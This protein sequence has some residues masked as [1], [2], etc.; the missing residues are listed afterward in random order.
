MPTTTVLE[1][2]ASQSA[3]PMSIVA[4]ATGKARNFQTQLQYVKVSDDGKALGPSTWGRT[5]Y[6][7]D[8]EQLVPV[9]IHDA[10]GQQ[11]QFS[12]D[13]N[14]FQLIKHKTVMQKDHYTSD[15]NIKNIYY[16]EVEQMVKEVTGASFVKTIHHVLRH[17]SSPDPDC[18]TIT[19]PLYKVHVD[20]TPNRVA[21]T[22][23]L[24]LGDKADELLKKRYAL[25]NIW[26]LLKPVFK[27]PLA[28]CDGSTVPD[29]EFVVR[30]LNIPNG[31]A[32][33]ENSAVRA[34]EGHMWYYL[35]GQDVDEVTFIRCWDSNP[36]VV[37]RC[38]HSAVRDA[39]MEELADRESIEARCLVFWD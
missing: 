6:E 12:L 28:Y 11:E 26:R 37:K 4:V 16:P 20:S 23:K 1:Q 31:Q 9:T 19:R 36:N 25:I 14:G 22:I 10:R 39:D 35:Y 7:E 29:T 15:E 27:D 18:L 3:A 8:R 13:R 17:S 2:V 21:Q 38:P 30:E 34:G 24:A 33:K 32:P 5:D